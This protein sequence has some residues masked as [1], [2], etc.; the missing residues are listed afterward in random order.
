MLTPEQ[1]RKKE[2]ERWPATGKNPLDA[3]DALEAMQTMK[4]L[5]GVKCYDEMP[6][7]SKR[8]YLEIAKRFP[9][10]QVYACGSRVRG[11]Y[12]ESEH[13]V[14]TQKLRALAGKKKKACS[15]FDFWVEPNAVQVGDLPEWADRCRLRIPENEKI[16]LPMWEFEK[17]PEWEHERILRLYENSR[18]VELVRIHDQ[19]Q[20]SPHSYCCDVIGL[21]VW[22]KYGIDNGFIKKQTAENE[23]VKSR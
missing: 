15:D 6:Y 17:I 3:Q 1:H 8:G 23:K 18:W 7:M 19:Y 2:R 22:W 20:V 13:D 14:L 11:D 9:G 16:P 4:M 5:H 10:F 12:V 21:Q